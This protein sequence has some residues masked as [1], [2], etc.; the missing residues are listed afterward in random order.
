MPF[1]S[2]FITPHGLKEYEPKTFKEKI[3]SNKYAVIDVRTEMEFSHG[4][5]EG[6]QHLPLK[7]VKKNIKNLDREKGYML[8]CATGHRSRAA[9]T[10]LLKNGFQD[11]SHLK[12]GMIA[13][14]RHFSKK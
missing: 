3:A 13:W 5:I 10:I 9:A 6:A 12:G 4:H 14:N 7:H 11:V 8:V 1:L 2:Y